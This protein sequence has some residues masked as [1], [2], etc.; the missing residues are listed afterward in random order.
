MSKQKLSPQALHR[1]IE[2]HLLDD[3]MAAYETCSRF[4]GDYELPGEVAQNLLTAQK[5]LIQSVSL[6]KAAEAALSFQV[7]AE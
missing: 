5:R 6:I 2:S 4:L 7:E 3:V 1:C